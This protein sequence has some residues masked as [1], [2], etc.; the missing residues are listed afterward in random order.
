MASL[1]GFSFPSAR[2]YADNGDG[3]KTAQKDRHPTG[4]GPESS[5]PETA[6]VFRMNTLNLVDRNESRAYSRSTGQIVYRRHTLRGNRKRS[7]R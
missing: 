4:D 3:T 2:Y 6:S 7:R 1:I 5:N